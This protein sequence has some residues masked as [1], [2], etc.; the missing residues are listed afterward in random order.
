MYTIKAIDT[1]SVTLYLHRV[2]LLANQSICFYMLFSTLISLYCYVKQYY[3]LQHDGHHSLIFH[4]VERGI[5]FLIDN[6]C[7]KFLISVFVQKRLLV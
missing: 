6:L 4:S 5:I 3:R 2:E 1:R 7:W